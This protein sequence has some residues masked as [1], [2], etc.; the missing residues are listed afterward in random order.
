ASLDYLFRQCG[1]AVEA[2]TPVFGGQFVTVEARPADGPVPP[3][4]RHAAETDALARDVNAFAGRFDAKLDAWRDVFAGLARSGRRAAV[5]GAGSKGVTIL[6][7]LGAGD[8]VACVVDVNP[9][10]QGMYV[11][12]TGHPIVAP[13]ALKADPPDVVV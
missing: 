10:K 2:V 8:E 5:W 3:S 9:R 4:P 12:G 6:N 7:L 13:S 1:F 11:A